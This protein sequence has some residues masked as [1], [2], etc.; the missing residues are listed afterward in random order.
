M[1][2]CHCPLL[3]KAAKK[4]NGDTPRHATPRYSYHMVNFSHVLYAFVCVC[5]GMC[6]S[7]SVHKARKT[8]SKAQRA[9]QLKKTKAYVGAS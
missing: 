3:Y 5:V 7:L 8:N 2:A 9:G 4:N 6:V 1:W